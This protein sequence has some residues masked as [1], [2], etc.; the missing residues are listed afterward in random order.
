VRG[1]MASQRARYLRK[2]LTRIEKRLWAHLR[3]R[4]V[5][6]LKFRRQHPIGD[7]VVDFFCDEAK[8]AIEPDGSGIDVIVRNTRISML[9]SSYT[10]KAFGSCDFLIAPCFWM[11]TLSSK[12]SFVLRSPNACR[13]FMHKQKR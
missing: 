5:A 4:K 2:H 8:L 11:C 12:Q 3:N 10:S 7:R 9:N 13:K 6:G 1:L